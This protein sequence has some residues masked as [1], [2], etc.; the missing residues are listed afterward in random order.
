MRRHLH[1]GVKWVD[2]SC[3]GCQQLAPGYFSNAT[4]IYGAYVGFI[5]NNGEA[6]VGGDMGRLRVDVANGPQAMKDVNSY[7]CCLVAAWE[8]HDNFV[9]RYTCLE[10]NLNKSHELV[11]VSSHREKVELGAAIGGLTCGIKV[12]IKIRVKGSGQG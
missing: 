12:D 9:G 3:G 11:L 7:T 1:Q 2:H 4:L 5:N 6:E 8:E 10:I